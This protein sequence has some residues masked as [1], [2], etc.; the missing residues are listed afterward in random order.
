MP[1]C[2]VLRSWPSAGVYS[3]TMS[4]FIAK[5]PAAITTESALT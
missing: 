3:A 1:W 2:L 5:P 4:A